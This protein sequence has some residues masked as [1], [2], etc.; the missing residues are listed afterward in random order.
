MD[1]QTIVRLV[2]RAIAATL[3]QQPLLP[4][5]VFDTRSQPPLYPLRNVS[6]N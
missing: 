1:F 4:V 2:Q 6:I 5:T 3:Q